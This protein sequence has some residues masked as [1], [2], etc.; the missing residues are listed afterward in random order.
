MS[1]TSKALRYTALGAIIVPM[2][3]MYFIMVMACMTLLLLTN[4][5]RK[6]MGKSHGITAEEIAERF[7]DAMAAKRPKAEQPNL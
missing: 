4:A 6:I 1:K 7:Y 5:G 2:V 3:I